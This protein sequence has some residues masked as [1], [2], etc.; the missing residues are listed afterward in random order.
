MKHMKKSMFITTVLMV[1]LLIVAVS[2]A[3]FAWYTSSNTVNTVATEVNSASSTGANIS[4]GWADNTPVGTSSMTFYDQPAGD[5]FHPM[6][7]LKTGETFTFNNDTAFYTAVISYGNLSNHAPATPYI[8]QKEGGGNTF[9]IINY[10]KV[11]TNVKFSANVTGE[12]AARLR[13]AVFNATTGALVFTHGSYYTGEIVA[14]VP[15][16]YSEITE[17]PGDWADN[18]SK[19]ST[20]GTEDVF[21]TAVAPAWAENKYYKDGELVVG[22]P[23]GTAP[24]DW[25]GSYQTYST[26]QYIN[27]PVV[28][29]APTF[30]GTVYKINAEV[31]AHMIT[32]A[33]AVPPIN[34]GQDIAASTDGV[35]GK[36][37]G[38][39]IKAWFDG[40]TQVDAFGGMPAKF[41]LT[42]QAT[43]ATP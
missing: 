37:Q 14:T 27:T 33:S 20:S 31:P 4:I 25:V 41:A 21:V 38:F 7:P 9:Y 11:A 36:A 5:G 32:S 40:P 24:S 15:K 10:A 19:Y 2:T 13:L 30:P 29:V 23:Y 43:N 6:V 42:V 16:T 3:T 22:N 39:I 34:A 17:Q 8:G 35:T 28:G 12:N 1:V 26:T 18:F